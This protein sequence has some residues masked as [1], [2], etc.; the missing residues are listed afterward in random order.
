M[1]IIRYYQQNTK[2]VQGWDIFFLSSLCQIRWRDQLELTVD[3]LQSTY[4]KE[5]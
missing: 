3:Y 2:H 5:I 1:P 4:D